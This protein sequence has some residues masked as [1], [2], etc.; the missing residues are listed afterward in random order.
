M[1]IISLILKDI[2]LKFGVTL[3]VTLTLDP[4]IMQYHISHKV[5]TKTG[6]SLPNLWHKNQQVICVSS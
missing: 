5:S 2:E 4:Y 6:A 1:V 3:T